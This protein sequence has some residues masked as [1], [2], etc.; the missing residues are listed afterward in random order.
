[1]SRKASDQKRALW[2]NHINAQKQSGLSRN[3]YCLRHGLNYD[4]FGYYAKISPQLNS[5]ELNVTQATTPSD[6][7]PL[8]VVRQH[9]ATN[10]FT[11]THPDGSTLSWT[12]AWSP[13]Q[14]L[15]FVSGWRA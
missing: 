8:N 12:T 1:M 7:I 5:P 3:Q 14:V 10:Q 15:D 4:Q 11:L 9:T 2:F 13:A 6:F